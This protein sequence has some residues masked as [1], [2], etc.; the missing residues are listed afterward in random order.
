MPDEWKLAGILF[1]VG[2]WIFVHSV[3][4]DLACIDT[5]FILLNAF[6]DK[7]AP[8]ETILVWIY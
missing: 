7:F 3:F 8:I 2:F 6:K 5:L 1:G 4:I